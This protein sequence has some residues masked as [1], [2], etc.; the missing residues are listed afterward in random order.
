MRSCTS[1]AKLGRIWIDA[2][3]AQPALAS[4]ERSDF[5]ELD[6][7]SVVLQER[8]GFVVL[9]AIPPAFEFG[10]FKALELDASFD[11]A[12]LGRREVR[13]S[14]H[15]EFGRGAFAFELGAFRVAV[16]GAARTIVK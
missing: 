5:Q 14:G 2:L 3:R 15:A 13:A 12:P 1:G 11:G 7:V 8:F 6:A 10:A 9:L 4:L 16:E